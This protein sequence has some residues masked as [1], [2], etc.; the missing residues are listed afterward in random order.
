VQLAGV[1][2]DAL[3]LF[4]LNCCYQLGVT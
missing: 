2:V 4:L 1:S 3:T